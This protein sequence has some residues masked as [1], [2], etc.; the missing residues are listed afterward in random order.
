VKEGSLDISGE[1]ITAGNVVVDMNT[2]KVTD[3][4]ET[5]EYN[6]KLVGHLKNEDFFNVTKFP[7]ATLKIKS[8]E[9]TAKGLKVKGDLTMLGQTNPVEFETTLKNVGDTVTSTSTIVLDRTKWNLKYG[10]A[11]F[12][13]NLGDKAIHNE[14]TLVINMTAKK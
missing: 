3:I 12:F 5:D 2:I 6:A 13:K 1:I 7:E 9:K 4:P 10:S 8:S 11:N 14:F